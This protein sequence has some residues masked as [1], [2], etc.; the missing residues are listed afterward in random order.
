M[1]SIALSTCKLLL[2]HFQYILGILELVEIKFYNLLVIV[3]GIDNGF[4]RLVKIGQCRHLMMSHDVTQCHTMQTYFHELVKAFR[5]QRI[6]AKQSG[7][8]R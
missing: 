2:M 7:S 8:V 5:G 4:E 6:T 1:Y 3:N